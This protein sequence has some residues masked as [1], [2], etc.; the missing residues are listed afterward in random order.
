MTNSMYELPACRSATNG[1]TSNV[2]PSPTSVSLS[3]AVPTTFMFVSV[4]AILCSQ[5]VA[6]LCA[7]APII[8][9][10]KIRTSGSL[11]SMI[12]SI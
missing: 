8:S 12:L 7:T 4:R 10:Q 11:S 1:N 3:N 2:V 5:F 9:T 6:S